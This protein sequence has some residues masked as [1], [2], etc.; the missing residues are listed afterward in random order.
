MFLFWLA[1]CQEVL[2]DQT[3]CSVHHFHN[4]AKK[5][6]SQQL[7][8]VKKKLVWKILTVQYSTVGGSIFDEKTILNAITPEMCSFLCKTTEKW[9]KTMFEVTVG[10]RKGHDLSVR[11]LKQFHNLV[12]FTLF[13]ILSAF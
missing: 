6:K 2:A 3:H 7:P 11:Y 8:T 9:M 12:M 4:A 13:N 10:L 1:S 5:N